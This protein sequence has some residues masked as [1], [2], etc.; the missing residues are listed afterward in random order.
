[1]KIV[2]RNV[3]LYQPDHI[4]TGQS[5]R[6]ERKKA[7]F[8]LRKVA[9]AMNVSPPYLSD[10]ERGNRAWSLKLS[11]DFNSALTSLNIA[12]IQAAQKGS[13]KSNLFIGKKV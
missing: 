11:S 7:G 5:A 6:N 3:K 2:L 10:L 1:M 9:S 4:A 13:K 8:S 12:R